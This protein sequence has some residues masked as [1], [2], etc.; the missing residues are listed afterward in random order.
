[1]AKNI[2]IIGTSSGIGNELAKQLLEEGQKIF[3]YGR[4]LP[5]SKHANFLHHPLDVTANTFQLTELPEIIDGLVYCPGSITLKPLRALKP[6]ELLEDFRLNALGAIQTLQQAYKGLRKSPSASVV[7]FSSVAVQTGMSF[8]TSV[9]AA[10]G[11]IEGITRAL[12]AEL[13]PTVRVNAIAPSLTDTPLASKFLSSEE[14]KEQSAQKHPLKRLGTP[15]DQAAAAAF[16]LS[17]KASWITGQILPV[18]GGMSA[19]R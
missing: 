4:S 7:L 17:D 13:A 12:A 14:K 6:E 11:A 5:D 19:I 15:L 2:V 1:M 18:D 9:A 10:K 8:H 16:L 3:S